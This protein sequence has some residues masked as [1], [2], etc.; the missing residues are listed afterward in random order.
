VAEMIKNAVGRLVPQEING[1]PQTPFLGA[2]KFEPTGRT[3]GTPIRAC[4]H[5][6]LDKRVPT[7]RAALEKV[8]LRDGM[9]IGMHHHMRNGDQIA[10]PLF[11][12][13]AEM[14]IKD[15]VF[16][17]SAVFPCH[18]PLIKHLD[19]G[20][21]HHIEGS[22]NGPIGKYCS[23]G[24]MKGM[25]ILRSH[26]G[27]YQAIQ[28]GD[29]HID[30]GIVPAP[31]ADMMGNATGAYGPSACGSLGFAL[32]D[33]EY[34]DN[35]I[36]VTD[37]LVEVPCIP[38]EIQ[39]MS[40]DV[41]VEVPKIGDPSKIVS[42]TTELTK[43]PTR[44][45]ISKHVADFI[46]AAGYLGQ[47]FQAGAG[48][49]SLAAIIFI[50]ER[51]RK[52]GLRASF[53]RGGSTK[54][55]VDMLNEGLIGAILDGQTFDLAG[56]KSIGEH[57][58]HVP[59]TPFTSYNYHGKGNWAPYIGTAV[60]GA[61]EVDVNFQANVVTHSD[62]YLLHGIGG[63][64]NTLFG[65][66]SILAFPLFRGRIP[67]VMDQVTTVCAPGEL[68]TVVITERG[69]AVN[70]KHRNGPAILERIQGSGLP[71]TTIEELHDI[72]RKMC[73]I[74]EP[75]DVDRSRPIA[76]IKWVDGTVIDTVYKVNR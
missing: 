52:K 55:L 41:V 49:I 6:P 63:W 39:G 38:W 11:D 64:Q 17:P 58:R 66:C 5:Y 57:P 56:V 71:L 74:P 48:G 18:E 76:A 42:G 43:S 33:S 60:L 70:P 32:A 36:V 37:N 67:I 20:V 35:V 22:M 12:T 61:T 19:S 25:A 23:E 34:A 47:P 54:V 1:K 75:P 27:R 46:E 24:R 40:V 29:L 13:I 16:A 62:G 30:I 2:G 9:T 45:L 50:A 68:I 28:D 53:A 4:H 72:G 31:S 44:L 14:G 26:G 3:V 65:E 15:I 21:I 51:M 69:I 10:V 7:M 73:G 8:G 59:T